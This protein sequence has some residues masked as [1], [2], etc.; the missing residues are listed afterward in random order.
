MFLGVVPLGFP[1]GGHTTPALT[2]NQMKNR[3]TVLQVAKSMGVV[4]DNP[5]AWSIGS[6]MAAKYVLEFNEPPPKDNRPKTSGSGS[7]CFALY[8]STWAPR[9][10]DAIKEHVD[11]KQV[12]LTLFEYAEAEADSRS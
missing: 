7:H 4:L 6:A 2:G 10:R 3:I 1:G 5:T 11:A 9:I 8:P 12:Q